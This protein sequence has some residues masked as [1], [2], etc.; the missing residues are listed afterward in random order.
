MPHSL[1]VT[2]H[3][4]TGRILVFKRCAFTFGRRLESLEWLVNFLKAEMSGEV[5]D[6]CEQATTVRNE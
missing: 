6:R 3:K 2:P 4:N 1:K 5:Y